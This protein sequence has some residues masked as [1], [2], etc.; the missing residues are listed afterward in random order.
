MITNSAVLKRNVSTDSY[1]NKIATSQHQ[2][3]LQMLTASAMME[4]QKSQQERKKRQGVIS[5]FDR[6]IHGHVVKTV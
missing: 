2:S 5:N 3:N 4:R 1:G 6:R